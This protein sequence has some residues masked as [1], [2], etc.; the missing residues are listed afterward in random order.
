[1]LNSHL[2]TSIYLTVAC[3]IYV[4]V[5]YKKTFSW[6]YFKKL[7]LASMMIIILYLPEGLLL[8]ENKMGA[9]YAVFAENLMSSAGLVTSCA[10][11]PLAYF[12]YSFEELKFSLS[13]IHSFGFY[14]S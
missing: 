9:N 2:V 1:M 6:P 7:L 8:L 12:I 13:F 5:E 11:H 3:L 10:F 4:L 14:F